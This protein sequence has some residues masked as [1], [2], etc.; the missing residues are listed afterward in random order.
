MNQ[1]MIEHRLY[2]TPET[3]VIHAKSGVNLVSH[4]ENTSTI[5]NKKGRQMTATLSHCLMPT[6][7]LKIMPLKKKIKEMAKI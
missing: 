3:I 1:V 7:R 5:K 2:P 4:Q 6:E